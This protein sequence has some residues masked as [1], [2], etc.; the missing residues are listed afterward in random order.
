[1]V[2]TCKK[3]NWKIYKVLN[4]LVFYKGGSSINTRIIHKKIFGRS[5]KLLDFESFKITVYY[6]SRNG[7]YFL[8][9]HYP[10]HFIPYLFFRTLHLIF[11]VVF[12]GDHKIER[13][14]VRVQGAYDGVIGKMG[15]RKYV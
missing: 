7:I 14:K 5:I 15:K 4:S 10:V 8:K 3:S 11:R 1:M 2:C 6:E 12:F 9:K 13:M